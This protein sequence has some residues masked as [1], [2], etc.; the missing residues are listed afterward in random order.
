MAFTGRIV[1]IGENRNDEQ[2][3][4][5]KITPWQTA[6]DA[7]RV[8]EA[9]FPSN[10]TTSVPIGL[11]TGRHEMVEKLNNFFSGVTGKILIFVILATLLSYV[12]S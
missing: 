12:M 11:V 6:G 4:D 10:T 3:V 7:K 2:P 1:N 9:E 5:A 8:N